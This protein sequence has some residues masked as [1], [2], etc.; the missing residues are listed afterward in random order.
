MSV[1]PQHTSYQTSP[2]QNGTVTPHFAPPGR[3]S[4]ATTKVTTDAAAPTIEVEVSATPAVTGET[5]TPAVTETTATE[6]TATETTV[7]ETTAA[8]PKAE[9]TATETEPKAES[10]AAETAAK[11]KKEAAPAAKKGGGKKKKKAAAAADE[12][13]ISG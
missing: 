10:K 7:T 5:P 2:F 13:Q 6:T 3:P 1:A 12:L 8:E 11:D 9:T 4:V